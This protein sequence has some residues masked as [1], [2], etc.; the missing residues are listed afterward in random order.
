MTL[1]SIDNKGKGKS[2]I[3]TVKDILEEA[4]RDAGL[5][6]LP[7][8]ED[9]LKHMETRTEIMSNF[10]QES[11]QLDVDIDYYKMSNK[12]LWDVIVSLK[13]LTKARVL[14][15]QSLKQA[16]N[17]VECVKSILTAAVNNNMSWHTLNREVISSQMR[18]QLEDKNHAG[19]EKSP[20]HA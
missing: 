16:L 1:Q 19:N 9:L 12:K 20:N 3:G 6:F 14:T 17:D 4:Y 8:N 13:V 11:E 18:A 5:D 2:T 7:T 15:K 10:S